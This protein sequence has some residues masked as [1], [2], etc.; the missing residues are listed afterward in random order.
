M[1]V[2]GNRVEPREVETALLSLGTIRHAYVTLRGGPPDGQRLV[3]YVVPAVQP[4]PPSSTL[5]RAL[6]A[7]LPAYMVP[8][9]FVC[10]DALPLTLHGKVDQRLLPAPDQ[11]R[12]ALEQPYVAPRTPVEHTL[13]TLWAEVL[14]LDQVGVEDAFL[15]LDGDSLQAAQIVA[16]VL[17]TYHVQV[18]LR[19]LFASPTIAAMAVLVTQALAEQT[20][21]ELLAQLLAEVEARITGQEAA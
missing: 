5:R 13:A 11:A 6:A 2:R 7:R 9:A 20:D 17:T 12:P 16:R 15:D 8:N 1:K 21:P 18:P 4:P 10:L 3:A 14:R 19:T